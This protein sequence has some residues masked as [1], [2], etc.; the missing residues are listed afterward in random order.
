MIPSKG[1]NRQSLDFQFQNSKSSGVA[2][3]RV[4]IDVPPCI[5]IAKALSCN[6][7]EPRPSLSVCGF[8]LMI[9]I[10]CRQ[11]RNTSPAPLKSYFPLWKTF[12]NIR[13]FPQK[14]IITGTYIIVIARRGEAHCY[15]WPSAISS[16]MGVSVSVSANTGQ[17]QKPRFLAIRRPLRIRPETIGTI[18]RKT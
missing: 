5:V 8:R 12:Y 13:F 15:I 1:K 7:N 17:W 11:F 10:S 16:R 18:R 14:I 2:W 6:P 3:R 4:D 9:S